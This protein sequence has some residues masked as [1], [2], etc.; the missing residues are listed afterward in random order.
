[1]HPIVHPIVHPLPVATLRPR[2]VRGHLTAAGAA[3]GRAVTGAA[4][5]VGGLVATLFGV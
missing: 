3:V 4:R 2:G 5:V 1:M